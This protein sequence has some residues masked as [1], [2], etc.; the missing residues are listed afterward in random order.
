MKKRNIAVLSFFLAAASFFGGW[1]A[2]K[3]LNVPQ[4]PVVR[5]PVQRFEI[6][7]VTAYDPWDKCVGKW[8]KRNRNNS[9]L[10]KK[11]SMPGVASANKLLPLGT[12]LWIPGI[13]YHGKVDDTGGG[14]RQSAK[15]GTYHIDLRMK[16]HADAMRFG[17]RIMMVFVSPKKRA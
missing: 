2:G 12:R 3:F 13:G 15:Q 6:M 17:R 10:R 11:W 14:M 8:A 1:Q 7:V 16:R 4:P 5:F 9:V